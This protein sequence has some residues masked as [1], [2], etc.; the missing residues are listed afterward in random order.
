MSETTSRPMRARGRARRELLLDATIA[1]IA[2]GGI[3]AVTHRS[4][5]AA[6]GVPHSSTTYFFDSLDDMIGEA[7]AH[8]MAAELERLEQFRSVLVS[9]ANS[10]GAAI[11]EFVEI[12]RSQSQDHTVA[13]FEIYLFASRHPALRVH[14]EKILDETRAL[15]AAV[16]QTNGVTDPH[17]A[18]A[19]VALIDGFALH[20]I[21]R[22]EEV[23]FQSLAHALRAAI[24]G[25]VTLA[26]TSSLGEGDHSP[27]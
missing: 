7:V 9:G 4:V 19:V 13:Q 26:A 24:V 23:Q 10:P 16:L 6:A 14:V 18:A 5:A 8:A 2:E 1:I 21:A 27:A 11:D 25:F 3:A 22:S 12:V 15:A 17:A 20:R